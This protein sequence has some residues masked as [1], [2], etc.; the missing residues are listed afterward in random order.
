MKTT[1]PQRSEEECT[2]VQGKNDGNLASKSGE[3][4]REKYNDEDPAYEA[5]QANER[6]FTAP[7]EEECSI[8]RKGDD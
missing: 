3:V 5:D 2:M 1:I 7:T 4:D 8:V 6:A